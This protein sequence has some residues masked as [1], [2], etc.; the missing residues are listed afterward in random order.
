[1]AINQDI[2]T[3]AHAELDSCQDI[4][5]IFGQY[6]KKSGKVTHS[7]SDVRMDEDKTELNTLQ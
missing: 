4:S 2:I 1:M 3:V 5:D 7:C 6:K